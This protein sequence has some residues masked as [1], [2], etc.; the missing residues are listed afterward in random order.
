MGTENGDGMLPRRK[1]QPI[2]PFRAPPESHGNWFGETQW[3]TVRSG[4][5]SRNLS[6]VHRGQAKKHGN[7]VRAILSSAKMRSDAP[8]VKWSPLSQRAE[9]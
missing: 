7:D 3:P 6:D 1:L 2:E 5:P 8:V 4:Y 9:S